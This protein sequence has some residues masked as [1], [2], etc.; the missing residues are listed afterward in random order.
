MRDFV[1]KVFAGGASGVSAGVIVMFWAKQVSIL[2][3]F[4]WAVVL[5]PVGAA[6]ALAA[7]W[8]VRRLSLPA[9]QRMNFVLV[10]ASFV[11]SVVLVY[12]EA[13]VFSFFWPS[14]VPDP[15]TASNLVPG[16]TT[17]GLVAFNLFARSRAGSSGDMSGPAR[18]Q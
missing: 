14:L 1:K 9:G 8:T 7:W 5:A 18:Q 11:V 10:A 2:G 3:F 12:L 13:G 16:V 15:I 6:T 4:F 17:G